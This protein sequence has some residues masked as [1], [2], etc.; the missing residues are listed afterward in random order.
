MVDP[1]CVAVS[2][3]MVVSQVCPLF[4]QSA[5]KFTSLKASIL[6][7]GESSGV[8]LSFCHHQ[9]A[10]VVTFVR[11]AI[12]CVHAGIDDEPPPNECRLHKILQ[13]PNLLHM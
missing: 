13:K 5:K 10:V 3:E 6:F 1:G 11:T 9:V 2:F 4:P 8:D 7:L 12:R